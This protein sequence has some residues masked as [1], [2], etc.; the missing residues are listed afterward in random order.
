MRRKEEEEEE[1]YINF[2]NAHRD[3]GQRIF[4]IRCDVANDILVILI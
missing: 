4:V 3:R 1:E 2:G